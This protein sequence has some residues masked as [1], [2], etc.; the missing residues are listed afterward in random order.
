MKKIFILEDEPVLLKL[1]KKHLDMAGH[2]VVASDNIAEATEIIKKFK[3]D[4]LFIDQG[5]K[6]E[7]KIGLDFL[8][9]AKTM[10]PKAKL[11]MLTNYSNTDLKESVKKAG[12]DDFLIKLNTPPNTLAKYV[13]KLFG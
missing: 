7:N 3:A 4:V 9:S 11:I 6:N 13:E 8:K 5:L 10:L 1:Y 12:G 2:E